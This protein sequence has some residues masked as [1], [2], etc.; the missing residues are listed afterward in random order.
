AE[1]RRVGQ[2]GA[3][4]CFESSECGSPAAA[5]R[6]V[7]LRRTIAITRVRAQS[8]EADRWEK[9][10]NAPGSAWN[11]AGGARP[12]RR[13]KGHRWRIGSMASSPS[14]PG[15]DASIA[16][17]RRLFSIALLRLSTSSLRTWMGQTR[18]GTWLSLAGRA[19]A[20]SS[21]QLP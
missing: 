17:R 16:L 9:E 5:S 11:R 14:V 4:G 8:V 1:G 2:E 15:T 12:G 20:A 18:R 10:A 6:T 7:R 19:T 21:E 13:D 3:G